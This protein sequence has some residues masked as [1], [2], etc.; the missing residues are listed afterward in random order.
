MAS[1]QA[2]APL[3]ADLPPAGRTRTTMAAFVLGVPLATAILCS[4]HF[5]PYSTSTPARY[6]K[7]PAEQVEVLMF[8]MALGALTAKLLSCVRERRCSPGRRR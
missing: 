8:C 7:H 5:G 1:S 3:A 6:V 4:I 2:A